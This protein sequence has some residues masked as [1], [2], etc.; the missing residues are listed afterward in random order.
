M[1][2]KYELKRTRHQAL[3]NE[4]SS[5][6]AHYKELSTFCS[7][8]SG[9]FFTQDRNKG[10]RKH[11]N[12]YDN[13][14]LRALGVL[15]AGMMSGNTSP[16][17]PWF[18]LAVHDT[19]LMEY[20][21]VKVWL[22]QVTLLMRDVFERS[23]TYR[24]LHKAYRE[25]GCFG[26]A[27]F[28]VL[29]NYKTV[30]W[31]HSS[32]AGEYCIATDYNG[33]VNTFYR[34]YEITV[35]QMVDEFGLEN[36]SLQVQSLFK[37]GKGFDSW[38]PI[39][40]AIQP[41]DA[42][43]G[44][45]DYQRKDNKNMAFSSCYY[46]TSGDKESYLR[47]SGFEEFPIIA[48]RWDTSGG[49]IYGNSPAMEALG[50]IKQL[51]HEQYR[52]AQAIDFK[53]LPSMQAP[54]SAKGAEIKFLPGGLTYVDNPGRDKAISSAFDVNLDLSHLLADIEDVRGRIDKAFYVDL[55][56]MIA[57][58]TRSNITAREIAERHE[59]KLLMLGPVLENLNNEMLDPLIDITFSR[60]L[61][62]GILPPLP[63]EL[64]GQEL[65]VQFISTLAQAQ[66]AVG[67]GSIDR[68]LG[69]VA[70]LGQV[71]KPEAVDK[72]DGDEIIDQ[73]SDMLGL[74]PKLIVADDKVALIREDRAKQQ[75]QMQQAAMMPQMAKAAK[76]ASQADTEKQSVL[77]SMM[78]G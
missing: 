52:K 46:E 41:R 31:N 73:V 10:D 28:A 9:R 48:P 66:R 54:T 47:E 29:E 51:Q 32:T 57:N 65:N 23:N 76:D 53:T 44:E 24:S 16:A 14:G 36:C 62:A 5:W 2:G 58:D 74:D 34:E 61:R 30:I 11:N 27:A 75:A 42:S 56:A 69:T 7:P 26:T 35:A 12:I 64:D 33:K 19:D 70:M 8:R 50:D 45:R 78:P 59:E 4:L 77:T 3:K 40:H 22:N 6:I 39:V 13:T 67:L 37:S 20:E 72:L 71:G 25:L 17:R 49:D 68:L 43:K 60:M 21:P 38:R 18:R 55:F 63:E 1:I 15:A